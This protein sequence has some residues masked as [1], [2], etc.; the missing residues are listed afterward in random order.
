VRVDVVGMVILDVNL[1]TDTI[2][3]TRAPLGRLAV[4]VTETNVVLPDTAE[5]AVE[6]SVAGFWK[7]RSVLPVVRD[8]VSGTALACE[9]M[10]EDVVERGGLEDA[11]AV[12]VDGCAGLGVDW[13]DCDDEVETGEVVDD[14]DNA[15]L[16]GCVD[17]D[18]REPG[19]SVVVGG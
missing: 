17:C 16:G 14:V 19:T 13:L 1:E 12:T 7:I 4:L 15:G 11:V 10:T 9:V 2:S 5:V 8:D 3:T 6:D 18:E